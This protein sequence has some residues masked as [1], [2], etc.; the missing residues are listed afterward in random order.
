[1]NKISYYH[2]IFSVLSHF[3]GKR[4]LLACS[5]SL[6]TLDPHFWVILFVL[7]CSQFM[8][9]MKLFCLCAV[10]SSVNCPFVYVCLKSIC[11]GLKL[12]HPTD[13]SFSVMGCS[14]TSLSNLTLSAFLLSYFPSFLSVISCV[15]MGYSTFM[16]YRGCHV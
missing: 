8:F 1:M 11:P 13:I 14:A 2:F 6:I 12:F 3:K 16:V 7:W 5:S 10:L 9:A 15:Q 4:A